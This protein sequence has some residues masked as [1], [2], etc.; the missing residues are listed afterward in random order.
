[1]LIK[2]AY[3]IAQ[4]KRPGDQLSII[5][6]FKTEWGFLFEKDRKKPTLGNMFIVVKKDG[7]GIY[8]LP[9]VP[10]NVDKINSGTKVP[11]TTVI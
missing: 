2:E 7:S 3:G 8:G 11:L 1:M 9:T 10:S 5:L 6:D 4:K